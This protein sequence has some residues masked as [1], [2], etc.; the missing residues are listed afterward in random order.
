M[1]LPRNMQWTRRSRLIALLRVSAS[2][3]LLQIVSLRPASAAPPDWSR[4]HLLTVRGIDQLYNLQIDSAARTFDTVKREA[5]G[6]PRGHFFSSIVHFYL[7]GLNREQKELDRFLG[8]SEQVIEVC[9]ALLDQN[10]EDAQTKFY[11]G[12]IYGY[13]GLAFQASGS[14][15]KAVNDGSKG[16]FLLEDAVR[17]NPKLYDAHMGFGLFR[18]LLAKIPHSMRWILN[19]LGFE[20]DLEG[21]LR[22]LQ[23]A[24]TR[25]VYTRSEARLYLA[26][27]QF[28]E[29][30][31][32]SALSN[33]A[34]L[35][36]E[37]PENTLFLVLYAAWQ[38]RMDNFDEAIKAAQTA[39]ELN[40]KRKI[41]VGEELAYSTLG[42]IYFTLNDFGSARRFY[43]KYMALTPN[44][45]RTP[46][47]TFLRAGLACEMSGDR[48]MAMEFYR[49]MR[50][51]EDQ[52]RGWDA[53]NY[54]RGQELLTRPLT[55]V[56]ALIVKGANEA[57]QKNIDSAIVMQREAFSRAAGNVEFQTRALYGVLQAQYDAERYADAE[58]TAR[59]LLALH[60]VRELWIL[61]HTW[62]R[63]GQICMKLRRTDEARAAFDKVGDYDDYEYQDR[64]E[65]QLKTEEEKLEKM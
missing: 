39:L 25:G 62:F 17:E 15:L 47:Y 4:I 2:L 26:Q 54:R 50:E 52:N 23:L 55:D 46:A 16:Y 48:D 56:E 32:D 9:N 49:R 29:G 13:R 24:A 57:S 27:F 1:R 53:L 51:P 45:A 8:E 21:G 28:S 35:R 14:L 58:I 41:K 18:Y 64:L 65:S 33:L 19:I 60:P 22:S 10:D 61:P 31:R 7:Y 11:L 59:E 63:L 44:D 5:P 6:D 20:G 43:I 40:E 30:R 3:L 37:Y 42:S 36:K 12:G 34:V 38:H